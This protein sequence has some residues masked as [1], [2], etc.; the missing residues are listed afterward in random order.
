[1]VRV[2]LP[3]GAAVEARLQA[4]GVALD[5]AGLAVAVHSGRRT[6]IAAARVVTA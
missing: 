3:V 1:V 5:A 2:T 6:V 4:A